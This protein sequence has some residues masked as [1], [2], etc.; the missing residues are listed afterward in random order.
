MSCFHFSSNFL[1]HSFETY[2]AWM[3]EDAWDNITE[4]D[5][6]T[7]FHG[8]IGTFEQFTRDWHVWYI[9]TEPETLPLL[10]LYL[11]KMPIRL[12]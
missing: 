5:K 8:L 4:L 9:H 2:L 3:S 1:W 10:G 6:L 11:S 7:G 12:C